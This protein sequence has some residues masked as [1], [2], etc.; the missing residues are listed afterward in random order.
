ME[1]QQQQQQKSDQKEKI[2][3]KPK[4]D[5]PKSDQKVK[6]VAVVRP[7]VVRKGNE[8]MAAE[9]EQQ[10]E[11]DFSADDDGA[12]SLAARLSSVEKNQNTM[13]RILAEQ[14]ELMAEQKNMI[15]KLLKSTLHLVLRLRGG[16]SLS[17]GFVDAIIT[18]V[19]RS[20]P[21]RFTDEE[22]SSRTDVLW[23]T[24]TSRRSRR[25]ISDRRTCPGAHWTRSSRRSTA[26]LLIASRAEITDEE[27]KQL[28]KA[29]KTAFRA[30][31]TLVRIHPP[32][33]IVCDIHG[34]FSDL[35]KIF[36]THGLPPEQ[37]YVSRRRASQVSPRTAAEEPR[38]V[39]RGRGRERAQPARHRLHRPSA[40]TR[41]ERRAILRGPPPL[42]TLFSAP[43]YN[44]KNNTGEGW[45]NC[46]EN[47]ACRV[48]KSDRLTPHCFV[49]M[50]IIRLIMHLNS[51]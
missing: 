43:R 50:T 23:P 27:L 48:E 47:D 22:N 31:P 26:R 30:Q 14:S 39:R 3:E 24:T 35:K 16:T 25:F 34:Q 11:V 5:Q 32:A 44:G 29:A 8:E 6:K 38:R 18:K 13:L 20:S 21:H 42:I 28:C 1:K 19:N 7:R 36:T 4:N 2:D 49:L 9:P 51:G 33:V 10:M 46:T 45:R 17:S 40:S 12:P 37:Q 15:E 41:H